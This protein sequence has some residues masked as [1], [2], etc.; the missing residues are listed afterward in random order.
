MIVIFHAPW[1]NYCKNLLSRIRTENIK[2]SSMHIKTFEQGLM[3][4]G[5]E[6]VILVDATD[7]VAKIYKRIF[8]KQ[9]DK[10]PMIFECIKNELLQMKMT[11]ITPNEFFKKTRKFRKTSI[12]PQKRTSSPKV[13][14]SPRP[15]KRTSSPKVKVSPRPQKRTGSPKVR[16]RPR[17]RTGGAKVSPRP[18]KRKGV[19]TASPWK[20]GASP[21]KR[22]SQ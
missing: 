14:V 15:Q 3:N 7:D 5:K 2:T 11:A 21:L 22:P 9:L 12:R 20:R 4:F 6:A 17:K 10:I 18:R 8:H 1:C 16:P 13:K 19:I